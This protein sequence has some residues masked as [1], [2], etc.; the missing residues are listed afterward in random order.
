[1]EAAIANANCSVVFILLA[2][3]VLKSP[4]REVFIEAFVGFDWFAFHYSNLS[5]FVFVSMK[6]P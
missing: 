6:S 2:Y 4:T 1:M 3:L 5:F